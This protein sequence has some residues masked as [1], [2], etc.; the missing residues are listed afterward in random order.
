M[1]AAPLDS[2]RLVL[3]ASVEWK[4]RQV[5]RKIVIGWD[6]SGEAARAA[7]DA[8]LRVLTDEGRI[9]LSDLS[10]RVALSQPPTAKRVRRLE[11]DGFIHVY[12]AVFDDTRLGGAMTVFNWVSLSDQKRETLKAFE[13]PES[14]LTAGWLD[15]P[16]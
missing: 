2:G 15:L 4:P 16:S 10:A 7:Y 5:G 9:S 12:R 8:I 3:V 14:P 6:A 1:A 11:E 13:G